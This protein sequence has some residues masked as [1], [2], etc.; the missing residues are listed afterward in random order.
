MFKTCKDQIKKVLVFGRAG[1][2]KSTFCKYVAHQRATL[3]LWSQYK[4]V[5][6]IPL[7]HL[8]ENRY[9]KLSTGS[10]CL[11]DLLQ[12]EYLSYY[13][14]SDEDKHLLKH[15]LSETPVLWLLDG[16]DEI[17]DSIPSHL[18]HL[19]DY[20]FKTT[21]HIVTSRPYRNVLSYDV[22]MEITGFTDDNIANYLQK[23]FH[24]IQN[25]PEYISNESEKLRSFLKMNPSI[26]GIA[27]IPIHLEMI[28]S[29]W[30]DRHWSDTKI[31]TMTELY[32]Y[33]AE[34]KPLFLNV[35]VQDKTLILTT[36]A[37][38][39]DI[40]GVLQQEVNGELRN[41]CYHSQLMTACERR[42]STI[43]QEAL[44][45][46]KCFAGMRSFI[47]GRSIII[48]TDHCPLW[49]ILERTVRNVKVDRKGRENYRPD[50][51]SRHPR[52]YDDLNDIDYGLAKKDLVDEVAKPSFLLPVA[53]GVRR[54]RFSKQN[55]L[56]AMTLRSHNKNNNKAATTTSDDGNNSSI[57]N[58]SDTNSEPQKKLK[59]SLI[60]V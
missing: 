46:Y 18:E 12:T 59:Q 5:V 44:A 25:E 49:N 34:W 28:C 45:I 60:V 21:H 7:R 16:Y 35:P 36:N 22:Q 47:L 23:F 24:L 38:K 15:Q 40:G 52:D 33:I 1:I 2:G 56:S 41:L 6:L 37:S 9:P 8:T 43:E 54:Q 57:D 19:L 17:V 20:L 30:G 29:V 50:F 26:C 10:Y 4:L 55:L 3:A 51:L 31:L 27:H 39:I 14:L 58:N 11:I 32:E 48:M 13:N 53:A 42:Y